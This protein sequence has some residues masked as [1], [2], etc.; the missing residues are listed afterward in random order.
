ML[1]LFCPVLSCSALSCLVLP[2]PALPCPALPC[3]FLYYPVLSCS[4]LPCPFLPSPSCPVQSCCVLSYPILAYPVLSC[5]VLSCPGLPCPAL[6][7]FFLFAA[8]IKFD[9]G[10]YSSN[11]YLYLRLINF[12]GQAS[13]ESAKEIG[14]LA[15]HV[16]D[17]GWKIAL[18]EQIKP[19]IE[20]ISQISRG[21]EEAIKGT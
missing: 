8:P 11:S 13:Q 5:P 18:K 2:Y 12:A 21:K 20:K 14:L 1:C 3:P 10:F 6:P 4:V 7:W 17:I 16:A 15:E 9:V 19:R